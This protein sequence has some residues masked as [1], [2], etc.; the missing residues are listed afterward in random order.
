M[1]VSDSY[2]LHTLSQEQVTGQN[3][4]EDISFHFNQDSTMPKQRKQKNELSY[5]TKDAKRMK[6]ARSVPDDLDVVQVSLWHSH[7]H[8]YTLATYIHDC[9]LPVWLSIHLATK[10]KGR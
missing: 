7:A 3:T 5:L 6:T 1:T 4:A 2:L 10:H 8:T 9:M